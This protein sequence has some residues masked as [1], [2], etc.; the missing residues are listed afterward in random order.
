[1][2]VVTELNKRFELKQWLTEDAEINGTKSVRYV[3]KNQTNNQNSHKQTN[4]QA[5]KQANK[6]ASKQTN[7]QT[8]AKTV[9]V[10]G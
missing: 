4:K 9:V 3:K 2:I 7:K 10:V 8:N 5:S 1:M 6:Q